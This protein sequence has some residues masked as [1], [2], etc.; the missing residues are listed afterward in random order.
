MSSTSINTNIHS[1][2][3]LHARSYEL[4]TDWGPRTMCA[5]KGMEGRPRCKS[6]P[7]GCG[8]GSQLGAGSAGLCP[9]QR[10]AQALRIPGRRG[11]FG[12]SV[13][14]ETQGA[15]G[16]YPP[17]PET[18]LPLLSMMQFLSGLLQ[19]RARCL[20][21]VRGNHGCRAS[22]RGTGEGLCPESATILHR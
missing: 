10:A 3:N 11:Q 7:H 12:E 17:L 14:Q 1:P 5:Q 2:E 9:A 18:L 6:R 22:P 16:G 13:G 20:K 4:Y 19:G 8:S 15:W 21:P